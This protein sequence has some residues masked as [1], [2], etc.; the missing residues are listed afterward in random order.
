MGAHAEG[1]AQVWQVGHDLQ[2]LWRSTLTQS[3]VT[4]NAGGGRRAPGSG[5]CHLQGGRRQDSCAAPLRSQAGRST[6]TAIRPRAPM[7]LTTAAPCS[8]P[9]STRVTDSPSLAAPG[10]VRRPNSLGSS[11]PSIQRNTL[12]RR[13]LH[14]SGPPVLT[15]CVFRETAG[16]RKRVSQKVVRYR[17]SSENMA[18]PHCGS[19]RDECGISVALDWRCTDTRRD[20]SCPAA[21]DREQ[22]AWHP[23]RRATL[24]SSPRLVNEWRTSCTPF[25]QPLQ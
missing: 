1:S 5:L 16:R 12:T 8:R 22:P 7:T 11:P 3:L 9:A 18:K 14:C 2:R 23:L 13:Q 4:L 25:L 24:R 17:A 20:V 6:V 19:R 10:S 21:R 15:G